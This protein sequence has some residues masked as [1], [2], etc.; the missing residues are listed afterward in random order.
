MGQCSGVSHQ[1]S[2]GS[3]RRWRWHAKISGGMVR[4]RR[5]GEI[6]FVRDGK[7]RIAEILGF[8]LDSVSGIDSCLSR[9]LCKIRPHDFDYAQNLRTR[10]YKRKY[11]LARLVSRNGQPNARAT[12]RA[13]SGLACL[14]VSTSWR[15]RRRNQAGHNFPKPLP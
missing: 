7:P 12:R 2:V 5:R 10:R 15:W 13:D 8:S 1:R 11:S 14:G 4:Q 3:R 6:C 9:R